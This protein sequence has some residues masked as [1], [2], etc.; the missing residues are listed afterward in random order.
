MGSELLGTP[1]A[2]SDLCDDWERTKVLIRVGPE[3]HQPG[4]FDGKESIEGRWEGKSGVPEPDKAV[5]SACTKEVFQH[6]G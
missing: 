5:H 2:L 3:K 6:E 4:R 1:A